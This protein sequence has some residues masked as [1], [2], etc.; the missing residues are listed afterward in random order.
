MPMQQTMFIDYW[1][2]LNNQ[3]AYRGE[4][5]ALHGEAWFWY[6]RFPVKLLDERRMNQ[7][8]NERKPQ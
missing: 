7:I 2:Q 5:E 8:I 3:L 4:P 6:N 1:R